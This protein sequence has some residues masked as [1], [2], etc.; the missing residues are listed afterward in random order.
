MKI[1]AAV[2]T[3]IGAKP[4]FAQTKPLVIEEVELAAA[5]ADG[6]RP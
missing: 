2:L 6:A 3:A 4:P 5:D 1:R